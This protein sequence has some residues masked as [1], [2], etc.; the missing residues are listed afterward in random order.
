MMALRIFIVSSGRAG[1]AKTYFAVPW[2]TFFVP[3]GERD[4]Y[5]AAY[6]SA[7][8]Q[9]HTEKGIAS[10]RQALLDFVGSGKLVMLDDDLSFYSRSSCGLKFAD[11]SNDNRAIK[12]LF[13]EIEGA[14]DGFAH[15]G[16]ADEFRASFKPRE[17][18]IGRRYYQVLSYNI[19]LFPTPPP[20]FGRLEVNEEM[21]FH[22]QLATV[23][24]Y[25][26]VLTEWTKKS[27]PYS[28]GGCST[29]RTAELELREHKKFV[30]LWPE[31][32]FMKKHAPSLSGHICNIRWHVLHKLR[33]S[34]TTY[35]KKSSG[36]FLFTG[37]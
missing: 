15:V 3:A 17:S 20:K 28:V 25:S 2:A 29:W 19:D 18:A 7:D 35:Q 16:I 26:K 5:L 21:D 27:K 24:C 36:S 6:P 23:G 11:I 1:N 13:S 33:N 14:L 9:T 22:L 32:V 8:I 10:T 12:R 31:L 30:K 37:V 34:G 4:A